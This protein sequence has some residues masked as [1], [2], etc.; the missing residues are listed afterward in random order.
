MTRRSDNE[1]EYMNAER[2]KKCNDSGYVMIWQDASDLYGHSA[3]GKPKL[4]QAA[5]PCPACNGGLASK[6]RKNKMLANIPGKYENCYMND[7]DWSIYKL[8]PDDQKEHMLSRKKVESFVNQFD[9]WLGEGLGLYIYSHTKGSGKTFLSCV[10]LN[11]LMYK[12]GLRG[13]FVSVSSLIET[14][15]T[16]Q[17]DSGK[18][19]LKVYKD[20]D[21]LILDDLGAKKS[22]SWLSDYL[23]QIIDYRLNNK[24]TTIITSNFAVS[25]LRFD[26]RIVDRI[27]RSTVSVKLP[28]I[29]I[30][31]IQ[32]ASHKSKF[33]SEL[34]IN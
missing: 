15:Q 8:R 18:N 5:M 13:Q 16:E 9:K 34:G 33:F 22:N 26:D 32:A 24:K 31:S 25:E 19:L 17:K 10:I 20:T 28:E 1:N 29:S 12:R 30:R 21:I 3:D 4:V 14:V 11:E 7:F 27:N 23:F 6:A 2:C